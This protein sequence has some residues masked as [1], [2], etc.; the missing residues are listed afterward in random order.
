MSWSGAAAATAEASDMV[1]PL[2]G[3]KTEVETGAVLDAAVTTCPNLRL[4]SLQIT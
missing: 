4:Q 2:V 1:V 3:A